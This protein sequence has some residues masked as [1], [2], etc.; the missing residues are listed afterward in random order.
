[1]FAKYSNNYVKK[2]V[3]YLKIFLHSAGI[4]LPEYSVNEINF[5]NIEKSEAMN[6]LHNHKF[7]EIKSSKP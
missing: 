6:Y 5:Q 7:I 1:M 4:N 3:K 2:V